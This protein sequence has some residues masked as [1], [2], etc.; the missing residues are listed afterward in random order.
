MKQVKKN[1]NKAFQQVWDNEFVLVETDTKKKYSLRTKLDFVDSGE[2]LSVSLYSG[3]GRANLEEWYVGGDT[4]TLAHEIGHQMGLLDEY[5]DPTVADRATAASP[6]I[7]TDHSIM[8][9]YY[10]EGMDQAEVKLRHGKHIATDI[11]TATGRNFSAIKP[12]KVVML[13]RRIMGW[14]Y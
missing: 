14:F 4:L 2:D 13:L 12:N 11:S 10:V 7:H 3:D 8:G 6:G 1:T 5:E 9:N